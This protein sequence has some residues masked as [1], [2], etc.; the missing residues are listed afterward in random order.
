MCFI[1]YSIANQKTDRTNN[2]SWPVI[3]DDGS[4]PQSACARPFALSLP[5]T[6]G[7][8]RLFILY[9]TYNC[10]AKNSCSPEFSYNKKR[11][12]QRIY[13]QVTD[14]FL[15]ENSAIQPRA[16]LL[17]PCEATLLTLLRLWLLNSE[18]NQPWFY[19]ILSP[20]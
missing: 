19:Q 6:Q 2:M 18:K 9:H 10:T 7:D 20:F 11:S 5:I 15:L 16:T 12:R 8:V 3:I 14:I 17:R 1:S 4:L 13:R